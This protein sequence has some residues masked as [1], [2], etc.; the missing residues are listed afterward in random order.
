MNEAFN[1]ESVKLYKTDHKKRIEQINR[2]I[3]ALLDIRIT[4]SLRKISS[5]VIKRSELLSIVNSEKQKA[6]D[7]LVSMEIDKVFDEYLNKES[8]NIIQTP[9]DIWN[10]NSNM[11]ESNVDKS[12]NNALKNLDDEKLAL[13]NNQDDTFTEAG[14]EKGPSK[15][16]RD[17]HFK[18]SVNDLD[19]AA[20]L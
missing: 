9:K 2:I 3:D 13:Q 14:L 15:V 16:K 17:S 10:N 20:N 1:N 7:D 12:I 18:S 5:P 11:L 19:N 4:L 8:K 6:N